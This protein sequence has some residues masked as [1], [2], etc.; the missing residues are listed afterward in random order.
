MHQGAGFRTLGA[1][2][3]DGQT[4][5]DPSLAALP[6]IV[7]TNRQLLAALAY[8]VQGRSVEALLADAR[9]GLLLAASTYTRQYRDVPAVRPYNS[10]VADLPLILSG[11]QPQ[12]F[13]P[14][15]WYKNFVLGALARGLGGVGIHLL[16]DSDLCRGASIRVPMGDVQRPQDRKSVV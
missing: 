16:I 1:P 10:S 13:H 6:E 14:G 8:D 7:D 9:R 12:L 4:L 2:Q 3:Q 15:V 11:H 5:I